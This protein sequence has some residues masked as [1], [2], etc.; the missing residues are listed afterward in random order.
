MDTNL[1]DAGHVHAG[2]RAGDL[3]AADLAVLGA[4]LADVLEDVLVLLLVPQLILRHHVEE[5]EDLGGEAGA[6][7]A[8]HAGDLHAGGQHVH[9]DHVLGPHTGPLDYQLLVPQLHT[10]QASDSLKIGWLIKLLSSLN[11]SPKY[12]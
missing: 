11:K 5:T 4:L 10:V 8:L 1:A 12:P 9:P 3:E 7:H 6:G 2:Q